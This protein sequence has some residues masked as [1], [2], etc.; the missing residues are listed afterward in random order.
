MRNSASYGARDMPTIKEELIGH[1]ETAISTC[2]QGVWHIA[3]YRTHRAGIEDGALWWVHAGMT[4]TV[5]DTAPEFLLHYMPHM[6]HMP[7]DAGVIVWDGGTDQVAPW[8][9]APASISDASPF[10]VSTPATIQIVGAAWVREDLYMLIGTS[11]GRIWR[12][13]EGNTGL[14][15]RLSRLLVTTWAVAREPSIGDVRPYR[16]GTQ[17]AAAT[18]A[19]RDTRA[20]NAVYV[21]ERP[22]GGGAGASRRGM[23]HRVEVRGYWRMQHYGPGNQNIRPVFVAAHMRG[24]DGAP[25]KEPRPSV[26]IV[27]E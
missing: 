4:E 22:H 17:G 18:G 24:P 7:S 13:V 15:A 23:G 6:E 10:M 12:E 20:I 25:V 2:T 3:K 16:P 9:D 11:R 26:H 8:G 1:L 19:A 14:Y 5:I 21:R 27:K